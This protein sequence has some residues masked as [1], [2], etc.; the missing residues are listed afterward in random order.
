[1]VPPNVPRGIN[2]R[3]SA[4]TDPQSEVVEVFDF[5]KSNV[6]FI[7]FSFA[8]FLFAGFGMFKHR[9]SVEV[10][11]DVV[12][13]LSAKTKTKFPVASSLDESAMA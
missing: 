1:M 7:T 8:H 5:R 12:P 10:R 6:G 2:F 4:A 3:S 13:T 11:K 9:A